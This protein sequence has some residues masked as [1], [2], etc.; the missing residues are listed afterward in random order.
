MSRF[1]G[2]RTLLT[3]AA[4]AGVVVV[5]VAAQVSLPAPARTEPTSL[6]VVSTDLVCPDAVTSASLNALTRLSAVTPTT[7][8]G[9]GGTAVLGPP[10][11]P[12]A[13]GALRP[14]QHA[15]SFRTPKGTAAVVGTAVGGRAP[16]FTM[17]QLTVSTRS[18]DRGLWGVSCP[19]PGDDFWFAGTGSGVGHRSTLY[20]TDTEATPATVV[21]DLYDADGQVVAPSVDGVEVPANGETAL[22]LDQVA[23]GAGDLVVHVVVTSGRVAASLLD[24]VS[25]GL[26]PQGTDWVPVAAAPSDQVVVPGLASGPGYRRLTLFA[27][28]YGTVTVK[29]TLVG[30]QGP[31]A[32][33]GAASVDID[34]GKVTT[35]DL[36]SAL[37]GDQTAAVVESPV[38]LVAGVR[39][40]TTGGGGREV[41]FSA[42]TPSLSRPA[43]VS[44][45]LQSGG[46]TTSLLVTAPGAGGR[47]SVQPLVDGV[48]SG[49]PTV[50]KV[51]AQSTVRVRLPSGRARG[52]YDV[53][54]T[55]LH[56]SGRLFAAVLRQ[57]VVNGV[58]GVT[59]APVRDARIDVAVPTSRPEL[60]V[61]L[62]R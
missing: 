22:H 10:S 11:R 6:P 21:V 2:R 7:F 56:G 15:T 50:V 17:D 27:P 40:T 46:V 48:P 53:V 49:R 12:A 45:N 61:G 62:G 14:G 51:A 28:G 8:A 13:F 59:V 26:V 36:G 31:F 37:A 58:Q 32:P 23:P 47:V 52:A 19:Q 38:P 43:V 39:W 34:R 60:D 42:G 16:G 4:A 5:A 3:A 9:S 1:T 30:T 44:G 55:P 20:L 25:N 35:V 57:A 24:S 18:A 29:V 33:A 41:A 54:L